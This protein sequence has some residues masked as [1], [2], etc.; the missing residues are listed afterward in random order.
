MSSENACKVS[1]AEA[2]NQREFVD[3]YRRHLDPTHLQ[4]KPLAMNTPDDQEMIRMQV[5]D[6]RRIPATSGQDLPAGTVAV[7]TEP[8]G[9]RRLPIWI[10]SHEGTALAVALHGTELPRPMTYQFTAAILGAAGAA[11]RETRIVAL[12]DGVF[13]AQAVLDNG[14]VIDARPSDV[15]NLALLTDTPIYVQA[16]VLDTAR[17]ANSSSSSDS[18]TPSRSMPRPSPRN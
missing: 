15:L 17:R 5:T 18:T 8:H 16:G 3:G 4:R 1:R 9:D 6:V 7:L 12:T 2:V 14:A 13:Y 11:L 10:G